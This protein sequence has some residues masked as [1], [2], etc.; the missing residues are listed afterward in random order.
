M[1][2]WIWIY[3]KYGNDK[4]FSINKLFCLDCTLDSIIQEQYYLSKYVNISVTESGEL[5]DF[6]REA[7]LA[8]LI[9]E[10]KEKNNI[11]NNN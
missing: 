5:L 2:M 10:K 6:E 3:W 11:N 1:W 7:Y 9:K 8:L 4:F